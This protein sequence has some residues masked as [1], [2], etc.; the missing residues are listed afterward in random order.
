MGAGVYLAILG[1][2]LIATLP[3]EVALRA[4]VYARPRRLLLSLAPVVVLFMGWD[5]YAIAHRHWSYDKDQLVGVMLPG[6]LPLEE[7]L[8]FLAVPVCPDRAGGAG[9]FG[10]DG[11][12][13]ATGATGVL[14]VLRDPVR[15]SGDRGRGPHLSGHRAL[16]PRPDR[17]L[18]AG[19]CA[20]GGLPPAWPPGRS[21][22]AVTAT[23]LPGRWTRDQ[24]HCDTVAL[25]ALVARM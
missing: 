9:G 13:P 7:G 12:H 1:G 8:F 6:G 21:T 22:P 20:P 23:G 19:V 16:Q 15:L 3:L 24:R 10:F 4:R 18:A 17:R 14:G 5:L 11:S 25:P 2:C